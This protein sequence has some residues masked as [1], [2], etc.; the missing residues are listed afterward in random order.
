MKTPTNMKLVSQVQQD[1]EEW[2]TQDLD[3]HHVT[4]ADQ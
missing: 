1:V 2:V 4:Q 3:P